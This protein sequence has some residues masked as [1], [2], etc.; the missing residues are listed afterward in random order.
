LL[1]RLVNSSS[2]A[3]H[4]GKRT[5]LLQYRH[6]T[7]F[8]GFVPLRELTAATLCW[9]ATHDRRASLRDQEK[10]LGTTIYVEEISA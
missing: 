10:T 8:D 9:W 6:A 7:Q 5:A 2:A 1:V 4:L 3:K